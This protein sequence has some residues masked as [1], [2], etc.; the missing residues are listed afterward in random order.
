[1]TWL[2]ALDGRDVIVTLVVR[3]SFDRA[4]NNDVHRGTGPNTSWCLRFLCEQAGGINA[5]GTTRKMAIGEQHF[6]EK[7]VAIDDEKHML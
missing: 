6:Y 7:L 3:P 2:P 5:V 4:Q 1:M